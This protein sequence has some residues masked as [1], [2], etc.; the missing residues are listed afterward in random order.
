MTAIELLSVLLLMSLLKVRKFLCVYLTQKG[1]ITQDYSTQGRVDID[2]QDGDLF[3]IED[4][5]QA[6]WC[7]FKKNMLKQGLGGSDP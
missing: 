6:I 4:V 5:S 1:D 2:I 3:R 7:C